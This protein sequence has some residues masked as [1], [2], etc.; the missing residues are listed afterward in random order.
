[1]P[2]DLKCQYHLVILFICIKKTSDGP[3]TL[4]RSFRK[5]W[6]RT[7]GLFLTRMEDMPA[8][9]AW[10]RHIFPRTCPRSCPQS[11]ICVTWNEAVQPAF[12]KVW[13]WL[14]MKKNFNDVWLL[15]RNSYFSDS[16]GYMTPIFIRNAVEVLDSSFHTYF[17]VNSL[18]WL[19]YI[20]NVRKHYI[21]ISRL[22]IN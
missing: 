8:C 2:L 19:L 22:I 15:I 3:K 14:T 21:A 13:S 10:H 7:T 9:A 17:K 4:W 18:F 12:K 16:K 11:T 5:S 20:K 1:M 6:C